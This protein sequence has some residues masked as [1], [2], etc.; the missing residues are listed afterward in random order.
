MP[1][2]ITIISD[3][4][5]YNVHC[6]FDPLNNQNHGIIQ[7]IISSDSDIIYLQ[8]FIYHQPS[9][10]KLKNITHTLNIIQLVYSKYPLSL[11]NVYL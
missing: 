5:N 1:T 11:W 6:Q 7:N 10:D 9:I 2:N 8:E 3:F 4:L